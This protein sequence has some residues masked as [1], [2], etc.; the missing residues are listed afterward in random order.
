MSSSSSTHDDKEAAIVDT[1][2]Y[3]NA[4]TQPGK[5]EQ[6]HDIITKVA[7][8][9]KKIYHMSKDKVKA[10]DNAGNEAVFK[11][12]S[13][14][15]DVLSK[16]EEDQIKHAVAVALAATAGKKTAATYGGRRHTTVRRKQSRRRRNKKTTTTTRRRFY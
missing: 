11:V 10:A 15:L 14:F 3:M 1:N 2:T 12:Q 16:E 7:Q 5:I 9:N 4:R 13:N 6:V 8:K